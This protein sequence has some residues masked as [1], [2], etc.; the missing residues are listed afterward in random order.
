LECSFH[1]ERCSARL[2]IYGWPTVFLIDPEG[3][4]VKNGDDRIFAEFGRAMC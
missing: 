3:H 2:A 4:L 1:S